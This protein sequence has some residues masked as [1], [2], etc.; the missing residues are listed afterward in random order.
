LGG[1]KKFLVGGA[2]QKTMDAEVEA[3]ERLKSLL[4]SS[5]SA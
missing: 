2:V 3:T 1:L 5:P 4:E